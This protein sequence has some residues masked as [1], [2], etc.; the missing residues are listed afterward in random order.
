MRSMLILTIKTTFDD[1]GNTP[2]F[3]PSLEPVGQLTDLQK[4]RQGR[5][6]KTQVANSLHFL[7]IEKAT[8]PEKGLTVLGQQGHQVLCLL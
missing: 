5:V 2:G 7:F 6:E 8:S 4:R 3:T 1:H